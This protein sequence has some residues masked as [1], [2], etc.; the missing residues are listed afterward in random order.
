VLT[1]LDSLNDILKEKAYNYAKR[2]HMNFIDFHC[3]TATLILEQNQEL[4]KKYRK[5]FAL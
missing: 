4:K 1:Q 5:Y 3:D 2:N